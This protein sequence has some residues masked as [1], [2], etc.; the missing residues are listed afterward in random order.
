MFKPH[1]LLLWHPEYTNPQSQ[2]IVLSFQEFFGCG[3]IRAGVNIKVLIQV[4]RLIG[5]GG[6]DAGQ[7]SPKIGAWPGRV[8]GFAQEKIQGRAGGVAAFIEA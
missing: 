2:V 3:D 8:V 4:N 5:A 1:S 7:A 6:S